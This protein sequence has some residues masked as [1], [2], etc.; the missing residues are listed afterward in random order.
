MTKVMS[1]ECQ[2]IVRKHDHDRFLLGLLMPYKCRA[3]LW[4]LFAFNY[5]IAKT[6]DVVSETT[7]GLIRLQWWRDAIKE[8]YD[9]QAPRQHEVVTPLAKIIKVYD[10]PREDFETLIYAREFDLEGV[11]P[12]NG[13]GLVN[14]CDFTTTPLYRLA[15]KICG[16]TVN[17][18]DLKAVAVHYAL[19]G[20]LRAVP[21]M[22]GQR[23]LM[24]P[25]DIIHNHNMSEQQLLDFNQKEKLPEVI[26]E[27]LELKSDFRYDRNTI[28]SRFL[29]GVAVMADLYERQ[30]RTVAYDVFDPRLALPPRFMALRLWW[31]SLF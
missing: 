2:E 29:K 24:L 16:E 8:I 22:L 12:A 14:Y 28:K 23:R 1:D 25:Q 6:R 26:D 17:E 18:D 31:K 30:L 7:I 27:V 5:E 9:G 15:L 20:T 11:A 10:L 19:I 21:Y 4:T 3:A 13:Q